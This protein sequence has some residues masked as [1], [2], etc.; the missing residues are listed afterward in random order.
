MRGLYSRRLKTT[1]LKRYP[2][3]QTPEG[4]QRLQRLKRFDSDNKD[5]DILRNVNI[6]LIQ[7][8]TYNLLLSK[9][10]ELNSFT[11]EK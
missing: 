7:F 8:L 3:R 2:D 4:G 1:S 9:N 10:I 5:E 6:E 11:A